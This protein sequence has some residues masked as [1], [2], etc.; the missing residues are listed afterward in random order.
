MSD[1]E[2]WLILY[3]AILSTGQF[4]HVAGEFADSALIEYKRR[5]ADAPDT[6]T[7]D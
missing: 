6:D 7:T 4:P 5:W 3:Q 2:I 1:S